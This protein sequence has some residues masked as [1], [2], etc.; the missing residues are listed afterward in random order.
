MSFTMKTWNEIRFRES[1][2]I[3]EKRV[4]L[5]ALAVY[6]RLKDRKGYL[7][8]SPLVRLI[9]RGMRKRWKQAA[10]RG[11][12]PTSARQSL[13]LLVSERGGRLS[14]RSSSFL[15]PQKI[16]LDSFPSLPSHRQ[17]SF[18]PPFTTI[19]PLLSPTRDH[20]KEGESPSGDSTL[21]H[22]ISPSDQA[23]GQP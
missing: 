18:F 1:L 2:K 23:T 6:S 8:M 21:T 15:K 19:P 20:V 14:T 17:L 4:F 7:P 10:K 22:R 13:L 3:E 9:M 12:E 16:F 5:R 11:W